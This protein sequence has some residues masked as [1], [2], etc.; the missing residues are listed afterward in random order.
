MTFIYFYIKPFLN[1]TF[2]SRIIKIFQLS[3]IRFHFNATIALL[4]FVYLYLISVLKK[5]ILF[6]NNLIFLEINI[7]SPLLNDLFI[8][9]FIQLL[10]RFVRKKNADSRFRILS[11]RK[12]DSRRKVIISWMA[13]K[14]HRTRFVF[15]LVEIIH[16]FPFR[17][18]TGKRSDS[19]SCAINIR[20]FA[21]VATRR[22]T[23]RSGHPD[24]STWRPRIGLCQ[25]R[26]V[27][28]RLVHGTRAVSDL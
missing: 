9:E 5:I 19:F 23:K 20:D 15:H 16:V 2:L 13:I 7:A 21:F 22:A 26:I 18:L 3:L 4:E 28:V 17:G 10:F 27:H 25:K 24:E 8:N 11:K 1:Y 6:Q 14:W 12:I